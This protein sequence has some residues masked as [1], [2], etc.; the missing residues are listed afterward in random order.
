ME[1]G[2]NRETVKCSECGLGVY[3]GYGIATSYSQARWK[4]L[5]KDCYLKLKEKGYDSK[6]EHPIFPIQINVHNLMMVP[7]D[8]PNDDRWVLN[9][10]GEKVQ[11]YSGEWYIFSDYYEEAQ[12][13]Y[14]TPKLWYDI[15]QFDTSRTELDKLSKEELIKLI[16]KERG[17]K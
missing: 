10:K 13:V 14:S 3:E 9:E 12:R 7:E 8:V 11:Y 2:N 5:C 6:S 4:Y 16:L 1:F 15:P 17:N